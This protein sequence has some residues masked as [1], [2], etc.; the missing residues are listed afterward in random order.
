MYTGV[1]VWRLELL[2]SYTLLARA[3]CWCVQLIPLHR[4]NA[5]RCWLCTHMYG[6]SVFT[7]PPPWPS[8]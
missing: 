2:P 3:C 5:H 6:L 4:I 7:R 8:S 1:N